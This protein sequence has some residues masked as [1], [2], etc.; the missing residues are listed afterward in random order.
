MPPSPVVAPQSGRPING[1]QARPSGSF[2]SI[3]PNVQLAK[4]WVKRDMFVSDRVDSGG[5]GHHLLEPGA[6]ADV[7]ESGHH[8]HLGCVQAL[9]GHRHRDQDGRLGEEPE[10]GERTVR[11]ALGAGRELHVALG[12]SSWHPTPQGLKVGPRARLVGCDH[13]QLAKTTRRGARGKTPLGPSAR[14]KLA[15]GLERSA[16]QRL[17]KARAQ[18]REQG[19][20]GGLGRP[21]ARQAVRPDGDALARPLPY[22]GLSPRAVQC[23]VGIIRRWIDLRS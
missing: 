3:P 17:G 22:P 15:R 2:L 12:P 19:R 5:A 18:R 6:R 13:E 20:A 8:G 4:D 1:A 23:K 9:V 10:G 11:V 14:A 16:Q 7:G 21:A